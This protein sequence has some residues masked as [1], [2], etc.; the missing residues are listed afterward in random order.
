MNELLSGLKGKVILITGGASGIG[1]AAAEVAAASGAH[2][3]CADVAQSQP[4]PSGWTQPRV[5]RV[6]PA[7]PL[8]SRSRLCPCQSLGV[9]SITRRL[10][11]VR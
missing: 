4:L 9:P 5:C 11:A 3:I 7:S 10:A 6:C 2:V 1:L 8:S